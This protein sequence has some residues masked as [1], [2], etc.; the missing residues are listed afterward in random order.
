MEV[1]GRE[2]LLTCY[3]NYGNDDRFWQVIKV[4]EITGYGK[5]SLHLYIFVFITNL[6]RGIKKKGLL[7]QMYEKEYRD[8]VRVIMISL[9]FSETPMEKC[10]QITQGPENA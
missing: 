4:K 8:S 7:P 3:C 10:K 6:Y 9:L 5:D 2:A 1:N